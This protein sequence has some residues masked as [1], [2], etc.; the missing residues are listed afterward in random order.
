MV[1]AL[2]YMYID[3]YLQNNNVEWMQIK[4]Y[5]GYINMSL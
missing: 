3:I 4:I 5:F 2:H 1:C